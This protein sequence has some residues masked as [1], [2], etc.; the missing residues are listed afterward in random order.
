MAF[1]P[2]ASYVR[3]RRTS[4]GAQEL[5]REFECLIANSQEEHPRVT[6]GDVQ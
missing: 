5:A 2:T 4:S 1:V 3:S 6:Q